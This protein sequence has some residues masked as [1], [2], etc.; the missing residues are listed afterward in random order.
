MKC[1]RSKLDQ[2][3]LNALN[4]LRAKKNL[5]CGVDHRLCRKRPKLFLFCLSLIAIFDVF[6]RSVQQAKFIFA[7]GIVS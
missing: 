4:E 5:P 7:F 6:F 3:V 1:L 2:Q